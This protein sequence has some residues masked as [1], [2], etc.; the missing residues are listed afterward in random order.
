MFLIRPMSHKKLNLPIQLEEIFLK[1]FKSK[2]QDKDKLLNIYQLKN[3][4]LSLTMAYCNQI[5]HKFNKGVISYSTNIFLPLTSL[6]RNNCKYCNFRTEFNHNSNFMKPNQIISLI[7]SAEVKKCKE[8]LL[9][10]GEKPEE[11]YSEVKKH[12]KKLGNFET[13]I[14]YLIYICKLILENSSLLPHSNPGIMNYDELKQL[15]EVN[16]SLGLMLENI[17]LRLMDEEGAHE[18]SPGKH[19][20]KRIKT[21]EN[22]GKLKI[23]FTTGILIGIGETDEEIVDSLLKIEEM[24]KKFEHIQ[25]IIIQGFTPLKDKDKKIK[26]IYNPPS[27]EKLIKTIIIAKLITDI[28]IQTPPNLLTSYQTYLFCGLDDWGGISP[29]TPDYI[30]PT[31]PWPTIGEIRKQTEELGYILKE[32][33]PIY[34]KFISNDF[35]PNKLRKRIFKQVN[36]NGYVK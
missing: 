28:P 11:K 24:N 25:E 19:P 16:A 12:L 33:L 22:A 10:M 29:I 1:R 18:F 34:P 5:F 4:E 30:N 6:C 15:K 7:K 14:E 9:T 2:I 35:I 21:I 31:H 23:P 3:P 13:T 32:R 17:S 26:S 36:N 8:A 27:I 20:K